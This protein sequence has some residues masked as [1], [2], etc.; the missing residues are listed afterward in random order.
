[1]G[2]NNMFLVF[3][4]RAMTHLYESLNESWHTYDLYVCHQS[5]IHVPCLVDMCSTHSNVCDDPFI[6][7][8]WCV[9]YRIRMRAVTHSYVW[10]DSLKCVKWRMHMCD[11]TIH[12][13]DMIYVCTTNMSE[14]TYK[15]T[16]CPLKETYIHQSTH[17]CLHN[18]SFKSSRRKYCVQKTIFCQQQQQT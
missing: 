13:R 6:C 4:V 18:Y 1:M 5:F 17:W 2:L 3:H 10:H 9:T 12:T 14:D 8:M 11:V 15:S 16:K 7:V